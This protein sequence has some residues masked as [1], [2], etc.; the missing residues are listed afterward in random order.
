[1]QHIMLHDNRSNTSLK[2][3]VRKTGF[4]VLANDKSHNGDLIFSIVA[5]SVSLLG[6]VVCCVILLMLRTGQHKKQNSVIIVL[7]T[8]CLIED[9]CFMVLW[10]NPFMFKDT[11]IRK[12]V[13]RF[14][15]IA[16]TGIYQ[17][18]VFSL[19]A[20]TTDR[21]V[22]F[23]RPFKYKKM[24]TRGRLFRYYCMTL[25]ITMAVRVPFF[26]GWYSTSLRY[27]F[28]VD[29]VLETVLLLPQPFIYA[30]VYRKWKKSIVMSYNKV[31]AL[32]RRKRRSQQRVFMVLSLVLF[33][34]CLVQVFSDALHLFA[35]EF[36]SEQ[37]ARRIMGYVSDGLWIFVVFLTPLCHVF[38]KP[39]V[40]YTFNASVRRSLRSL[41]GVRSTSKKGRE[42]IPSPIPTTLKPIEMYELRE[43][44][45][46]ENTS[47]TSIATIHS[48][49]IGSNSPHPSSRFRV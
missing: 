42:S 34:T 49:A 25:L 17:M 22:A 5:S 16:C 31:D 23:F 27:L 7:V 46:N 6:A 38:V 13:Q 30:A 18:F 9:C 24:I 41:T 35:E 15:F 44:T 14:M 10:G 48:S 26:V 29:I 37:N 3:S 11:T 21:F 28:Q 19:V 20:M 12:D 32:T 43:K 2:P 39:S 36:S 1:M 8:F 47:R 4:T 40:R 33:A 45:L